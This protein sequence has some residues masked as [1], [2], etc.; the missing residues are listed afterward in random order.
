MALVPA[1]FIGAVASVAMPYAAG[2]T[3]ESFQRIV[4]AGTVTIPAG[5][6]SLMW[7]WPTFCIVTLFAW[8]LLRSTE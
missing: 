3:S 6:G 2:A 7:S 4:Q 8:W 5:S 1:V